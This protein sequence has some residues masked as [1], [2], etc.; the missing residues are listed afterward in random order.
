MQ[1]AF[2]TLQYAYCDR[3]YIASNICCAR[4]LNV[5]KTEGYF[6]WLAGAHCIGVEGIESYDTLF[7]ETT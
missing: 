3:I 2:C 1:Y 7:Y 5:A 6:S 4:P